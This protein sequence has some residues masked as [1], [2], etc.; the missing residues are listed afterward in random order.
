MVCDNDP[1]PPRSRLP[2]Q[3]NGG[4]QVE[5]VPTRA[6]P[7]L[8]KRGLRDKPNLVQSLNLCTRLF[9]FSSLKRIVHFGKSCYSPVGRSGKYWIASSH[10]ANGDLAHPSCLH[11]GKKTI[12]LALTHL[13]WAWVCM[14]QTQHHSVTKER[15]LLLLTFNA[16]HSKA[17]HWCDWWFSS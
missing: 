15:P 2:R 16:K 1:S 8:C 3:D 4:I 13:P 14:V 9:P 7:R 6:S 10:L 17:Y 12:L 11:R 5:P